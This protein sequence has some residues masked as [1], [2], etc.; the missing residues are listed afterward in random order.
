MRAVR[1]IR[2]LADGEIHLAMKVFE[3]T[4]F[5]NQVVISDGLGWN[6]RELTLPTRVP[7]TLLL[8]VPSS[9]GRF[10]IHAGDGY[11]G[12]SKFAKDQST[13]IHELTHVWQG[14]RESAAFYAAIGLVTQLGDDDPYKYDHDHLYPDW[15]LYNMEQQAQIVEDWFTDG[16]KEYN[17]DTDEGDKRFYFIKAII[18]GEKVA[19]NWLMPY[20]E[21]LPGATLAHDWS[22]EPEAIRIRHNAVLLPI[23]KPRFAKEDLKGAG[24]RIKKLEELFSKMTGLEAANLWQRL[25]ARRPNDEVAREFFGNLSNQSTTKLMAILKGKAGSFI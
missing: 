24:G 25:Q 9:A 6:D 12:M 18:R 5:Y 4:I 3:H 7:V 11:Y 15:D 2:H 19:F 8:N 21:A 14:Q 1:H 20:V 22:K 17:P 23:L 16:R 10:V 13:L